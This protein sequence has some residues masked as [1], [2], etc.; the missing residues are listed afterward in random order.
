MYRKC[1]GVALS[2]LGLLL[3][4]CDGTVV[5]PEAS[6][7]P[8]FARGGIHGPDMVPIKGHFAIFPTDQPPVPCVAGIDAFGTSGSGNTSHLGTSVLVTV[9][10]SCRFSYPFLYG[11]G[12]STVTGANG[13]ATFSTGTRVIDVTAISPDG[14]APFT[15]TGIITG[16]TGR[17]E[18]ASGSF[19]G[20]GLS[21]PTGGTLSFQGTMSSVGSLE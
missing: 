11:D 1:L 2:T 19:S 17:F 6:E 3:M 20:T 21:D 12:T 10:T 5:S 15:F 8:A 16:G 4:A 9:V 13:D 7:A 14:V 18:G